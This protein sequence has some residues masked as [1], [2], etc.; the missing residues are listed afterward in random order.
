[1]A[2][3]GLRCKTLNPEPKVQGVWG[4]KGFG[5]LAYELALLYGLVD[6]YQKGIHG[7]GVQL[8]YL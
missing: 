4:F 2:I 8:Q 7:L 5:G 1:M 6:R 3:I